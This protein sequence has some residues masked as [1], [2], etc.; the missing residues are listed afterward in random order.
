MIDI[1]P[2]DPS[3]LRPWV[4]AMHTVYFAPHSVDDEVAYR[5]ERTD[6]QRAL[7]AF[8]G[9][10]VVATFRSFASSLYVPGGA[11]IPA[12]AVTNVAV[13]PTHRRQGLLTRM[14]DRDLREARERGDAVALLFASEA[15]IYGRYGFGTATEQVQLLIRK[16]NAHFRTLP[17]GH[18]ELVSWKDLREIAPPL[19]ERFAAGQ[20]G[21]MAI[22][23]KRWDAIFG[24]EATPFS[25]KATHRAV[26]YRDEAGEPQGWL[27][28]D[29]EEVWAEVRP[30]GKLTVHD[31]VAA[32]TAAYARLW[33]Y[34]LEVDLI[35]E[36]RA[37]QRPNAELLPWLLTDRRAVHHVARHDGLWGRVLDPAAALAARTYLT[38]GEIVIEVRDET[39]LAAGCFR[40]E[41]GPD[42]ATCTSTTGDPDLTF[43]VEGLGAAYLGGPKLSTLAAAGLV[44][45][46]R[47][48]AL[49]RAEAMFAST[50]VPWCWREF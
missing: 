19:Y 23:S 13:L 35:A 15:Q 43:T 11:C 39:G 5:A 24:L 42:G 20:P 16:A 1:R 33:R 47:T 8:D 22:N 12:D 38:P 32:T 50:I 17:E 9:D 4:E 41:G 26:I 37:E 49:A 10:R 29:A 18:V 27:H 44:E 28:Y 36:I 21:S 46:R 14:M 6:F 31:L 3:E 7:G 45:E 34:A 2:I 25:P 40:L 30:Q 48:G